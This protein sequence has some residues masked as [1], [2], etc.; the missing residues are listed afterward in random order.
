[1]PESLD[2]FSQ[3]ELDEIYRC[4]Y[5]DLEQIQDE[6]QE[7]LDGFSFWYFHIAIKPG[8]YEGF[9]LDIESNFPVAFDS[10][11]DKRDAQKEITQIK[12]FLLS[13]AGMGLVSCSPGWCT[14]YKNYPDTVKAIRKAIR[15]M[16][17][18]ARTTPTWTQYNRA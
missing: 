1:M 11:E 2:G 6:T 10:W 18:E 9:T 14:G 4:K 13:C 3:A 5:D 15:E 8:Y 16:R 17:E 12:Q 7:L